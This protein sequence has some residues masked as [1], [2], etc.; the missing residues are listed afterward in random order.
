MNLDILDNLMK[1]LKD[2]EL[3]KKF[4]EELNDYLDQKLD[5]TNNQQESILEKIQN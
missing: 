3:I 5:K 4:G 2:N 1:N